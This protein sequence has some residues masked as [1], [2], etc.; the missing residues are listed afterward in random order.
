MLIFD[1]PRADIRL[2]FARIL[3]PGQ[4]SFVCVQN[5]KAVL[6]NMYVVFVLETF[7]VKVRIRLSRA[8]I[9]VSAIR[10]DVARDGWN[11]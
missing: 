2:T 4:K 6:L 7:S 1:A 8:K 5:I 11:W 10:T 3:T 9:S